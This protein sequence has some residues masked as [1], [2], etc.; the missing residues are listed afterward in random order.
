ME[1]GRSVN[2]VLDID[3]VLN[4]LGMTQDNFV[5]VGHSW[6]KWRLRESAIDFI[7]L[8]SSDPLVNVYWN[9]SWGEESNELNQFLTISNFK[10]IFNRQNGTTEEAKIIGVLD[11]LKESKKPTIVIEDNDI[12][13]GVKE[14]MLTTLYVTV[15]DDP[16]NEFA[17]KTRLGFEMFRPN[18]KTG[19]VKEN[20]KI[21]VNEINR[22]KSSNEKLYM[23]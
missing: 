7:K 16:T 22:L 12:F 15:T 3:G 4:F 8:L 5:S 1:K 20:I 2:V 21:L 14:E 11:L 9:S 17:E 19:L 18:A 6:G 23:E 13:Q 10:N